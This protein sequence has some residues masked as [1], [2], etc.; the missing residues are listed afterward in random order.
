MLTKLPVLAI[1]CIFTTVAIAAGTPIDE[2]RPIAA[3]GQISAHNV[4]GMLR[5]TGSDRQDVHVTGTIGDGAKGLIIEGD[6]DSLT[7][8]I[9][10]PDG[11]G[12][13]GWWGKNVEDSVLEIAVPR[14]VNVEADAVSAQVEVTGIA[15]R[16]VEI[17]SVS[18]D[19]RAEVT[20]QEFDA[21]AVSG[22]LTAIVKDAAEIEVE[23]VSGD[24]EL[25]GS[26]SERVQA[27]SVSGQL[28]IDVA[29]ALRRV[30]ASVVSSDIDLKIALAEGGR[31]SAE[32]MS[33]DVN[34]A[35]PKATSAEVS[36]ESFSGD[37]RSQ[38]GTV[39][40]EEMGPG[41]SLKTRVGAGAGQIR[42]ESFSGDV[43]FE[44]N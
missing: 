28:R 6:Q 22:D 44:L 20:V 1:G 30:S 11:G 9:D 37:I 38:V 41:S 17:D 14:G 27:E 3:N 39:E 24:V 10:Y 25:S 5:I 32:S 40:K 42:I 18:G 36:I 43:S 7:I 4:S 34:L 15:S 26:A 31:L 21:E 29:G 13:G 23:T 16:R 8:R 19:V 33:G 12:W 2:T 35:M